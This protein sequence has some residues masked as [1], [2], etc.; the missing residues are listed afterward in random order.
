MWLSASR[1]AQKVSG[2]DSSYLPPISRWSSGWLA[3]QRVQTP[4]ESH[5]DMYIQGIYI[6]LVTLDS[7]IKADVKSLSYQSTICIYIL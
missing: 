3:G 4:L 6:C 2:S 1:L 7:V 5:H